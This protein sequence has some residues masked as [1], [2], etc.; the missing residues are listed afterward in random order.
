MLV[1]GDRI[2]EK[3]EFF[4]SNFECAFCIISTLARNIGL[5]H[6]ANNFCKSCRDEKK[7]ETIL[8]M[9]GTCPALYQKGN[10]YLG[11]SCMHDREELSRID[12]GGLSVSI[13]FS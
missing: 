6:L 11:A 13:Q 12:I 5:R 9:L 8:N 3:N 2:F 1:T 4:L 10:K 7:E